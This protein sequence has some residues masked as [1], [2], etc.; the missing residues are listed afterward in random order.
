M[1]DVIRDTRPR[2][3]QRWEAGRPIGCSSE[4]GLMLESWD[5]SRTQLL[6]VVVDLFIYL[7]VLCVSFIFTYCINKLAGN[8]LEALRMMD[9]W[10][11]HSSL[12]ID[13]QPGKST[14]LVH[15]LPCDNSKL[16][17]SKCRVITTRDLTVPYPSQ[18]LWPLLCFRHC[19]PVL[20]ATESTGA[21]EMFW[22]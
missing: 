19:P 12:V 16:S 7:F 11:T 5:E 21:D 9:E 14:P 3:W 1:S 22:Q 20:P 4:C 8:T 6:F 18:P 17:T 15:L 13:S 2:P 10:V